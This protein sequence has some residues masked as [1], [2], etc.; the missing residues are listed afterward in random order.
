M[1]PDV[2]RIIMTVLGAGLVVGAFLLP[3]TQAYL[4]PAGIGLLGW[5]APAPGHGADK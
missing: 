5:A 3:Q 4:L 2:K 1:S